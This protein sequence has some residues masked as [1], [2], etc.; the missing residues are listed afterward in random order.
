M[1]EISCEIAESFRKHYDEKKTFKG[2]LSFPSQAMFLPSFFT[3]YIIKRM[4]AEGTMVAGFAFL[5]AGPAIFYANNSYIVFV[6]GFVSLGI[7]WNL[8]ELQ[9]WS[10]SSGVL[11]SPFDDHC[12]LK[13]GLETWLCSIVWTWTGIKVI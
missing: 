4:T 3:G 9:S 10:A 13:R 6:F 8:G 7:A 5:L 11:L 1:V 2:W 12:L